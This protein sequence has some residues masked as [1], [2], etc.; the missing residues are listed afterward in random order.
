MVFP[1]LSLCRVSPLRPSLCPFPFPCLPNPFL[2]VRVEI[3][4]RNNKRRAAA[5]LRP[6][7][8]KIQAFNFRQTSVALEAGR[9]LVFPS[10]PTLTLKLIKLLTT[11]T[12]LKP[13]QISKV[14]NVT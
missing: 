11:A 12:I 3:P 10:P 13:L 8:R 6:S 9:R 5:T 1:P 4:Y 7:Q 2:S 14:G